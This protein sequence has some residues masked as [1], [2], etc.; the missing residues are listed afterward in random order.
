[1]VK[2]DVGA[3][4]AEAAKQAILEGEISPKGKYVEQFEKALGD[5]LG[6]KHCVCTNS[7][8]SALLIGV[9]SS[10]RKSW[11]VPATTMVASGT[12]VRHALQGEGRLIIYDVDERGMLKGDDFEDLAVMTV[13]LYGKL[14][15]KPK[16]A[17]FVV[18]DAAEV[19][20]PMAY[21]GDIVCFSFYVNKLIT[22]GNGG[23]ACTNDDA[24][25]AEMRLLRHHYYDGKSYDHPKDG[26]NG[27]MNSIDAAVGL[28]QLERAPAML[29]R[30]KVLGEKY[31]RFIPGAWECDVYW[32][33]PMLCKD[34]SEKDALKSVLTK[35]DIACRDFFPPLHKIGA[36]SDIAN[37]TYIKNAEDLF[38]KGLLLPLYSAMT[39]YEQAY[40]IETVRKFYGT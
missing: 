16:S 19:F 26:Y 25:A 27:S 40:V 1:M 36:V 35:H 12:A 3:L 4:E 5:Y 17:A 13:D 28:V 20:G 18:E 8:Y 9:R 38:D 10:G 22:T 24:L 15:P 39:D 29:A 21:Y 11:V 30:R 14:C 7:G 33:Q 32:Y 37:H 34:K 23:V 2:P 31:V 6:F